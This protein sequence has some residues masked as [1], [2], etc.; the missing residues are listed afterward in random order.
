MNKKM[1]DN[2]L[3]LLAFCKKEKSVGEIAKYLS[4]APKNVSVR[5]KKLQELKLIKIERQGKGKKTLIRTANADK[6]QK[7]MKE[8]LKILEK[9]KGEMWLE[10]YLKI[11]LDSEG[12]PL[13]NSEHDKSNSIFRLLYCYPKLVREKICLTKLGRKFIKEKPTNQ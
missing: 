13:S 11:F 9:N 6:T 5:L 8:V 4:I 2:D 1:N 12:D 7:Y 3:K 10:D